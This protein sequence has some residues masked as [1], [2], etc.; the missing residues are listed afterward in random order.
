MLLRMLLSLARLER[1][2]IT[3]KPLILLQPMHG[4][5]G[6]TQVGRNLFAMK[7]LHLRLANLC[8]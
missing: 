3:L 8:C 5:V 7:N 1:A 6:L 2:W 4:I